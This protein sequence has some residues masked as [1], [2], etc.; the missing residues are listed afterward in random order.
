MW[1]SSIGT[2]REQAE[3]HVR[4][5][6]HIDLVIGTQ[7]SGQ[8]HETSFAQVAAEWLGVPVNTI[9]VIVGDTDL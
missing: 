9:S 2:P 1:E 5:D 8:G 6:G 7:P 3:I 4:A